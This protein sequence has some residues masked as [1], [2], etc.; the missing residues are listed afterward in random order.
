MLEQEEISLVDNKGKNI[1]NVL[2]NGQISI[3][4]LAMF[5]AGINMRS[6]QENMKVYFIDDLT[7][8]MDDV[9]MLAFMD[10]LKYQLSSK[11]TIE[12]LFFITCDERISELLK[13]KLNGRGIKMCELSEEKFM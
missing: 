6:K 10:L 1:V 12:Q 11:R 7:A 2:S 13:Y 8:C 9:N 3:F 5:F 4:M